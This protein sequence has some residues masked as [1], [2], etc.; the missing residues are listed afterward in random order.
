MKHSKVLMSSLEGVVPVSNPRR[1]HLMHWT[2]PL[3][4]VKVSYLLGKMSSSFTPLGRAASRGGMRLSFSS[5]AHLFEGDGH[6]L[7]SSKGCFEL[8]TRSL[9]G[10]EAAWG[11]SMVR[12]MSSS[13]EMMTPAPPTSWSQIVE[14]TPG[15]GL[16]SSSRGVTHPSTS[17]GGMPGYMA[18]PPGLIPP[19][20]SIWSM[21]P[22][23]ASLPEGLPG[24]PWYC[25]SV[26]R[27][28]QMRATLDRQAQALWAPAFA[29]SRVAGSGAEGSSDGAP[30][31]P[32]TPIFQGSAG[33]PIPAGS[34][35]TE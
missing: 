35:A 16:T 23:K 28:A 17:M 9:F 2:Q 34:S 27:A 5:V 19:D 33:N 24:S 11:T 32:T 14:Q 18:P 31:V 29:G 20:Y 6:G 4:A 15:Y 26:G 7:L 21:P 13:S 8:K 3:S 22:Q 12:S 1:L 10:V 30:L 25:P